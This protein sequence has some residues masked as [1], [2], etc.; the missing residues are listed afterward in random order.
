[1][2]AP[3]P[4]AALADHARVVDDEA[5]PTAVAA[6]LREREAA[7]VAARRPGALAHR[8]DPRGGARLRSGAAAGAARRRAGQPQGDG[9]P[10]DRLAEGERDLG[11]DVLAPPGP[12]RGAGRAAEE[13]AEQVADAVT[14]DRPG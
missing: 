7:E 3:A 5:T 11:L 2:G 14:G 6:R 13:A 12:G 8:A 1:A 9:G 4:P 10:L